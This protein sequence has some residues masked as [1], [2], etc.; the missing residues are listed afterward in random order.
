[1]LDAAAPAPGAD[2]DDALADAFLSWFGGR[3]DLYAR[4]WHDDR[5]RRS[6]Y[7]PVREPLTADVALAH[8]RGSITVGQ[9]LLFPDATVAYAVLDLDLSA[10]ALAEVRATAGDDASPC[11]HPRLRSYAARLIDCAA[12]L[13]IPLWP[14]D[15]GGRGMHLWL[16]FRPRRPARA[17]RALLAQIVTAAGAQPADVSVEIF[18]KQDRPGRRGLSSLVKLPLGIHRGSLR[19]CPLLDDR[20]EPI[21]DP[22]AALARL[23]PA[24]DACVAD[25]LGRRLAP[26]P[27]PEVD[28]PAGPA[29]ALVAVDSPRS[30]AERLRAI[31][32][33][34]DERAACER[35]L[36]GCAV[37][38]ALVR[39]AY[40][41]RRLEPAELSAVIYTLGL[42]GPACQLADDVLA[43]ARAPRAEL[44][45]AR[46]GIPSPAGCRRLRRI[47][48]DAAADCRCFDG[49]D[50][51]PY[52]TPA[53]FATGE[54]A[55]APPSWAPFA[56]WL[57]DDDLVAD[58]IETLGQW[59]R[60]IDERLER[61]E[62]L[63]ADADPSP[64]PPGAGAG[65]DRNSTGGDA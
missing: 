27:A 58:P 5:R 14:A 21:G 44:E 37:L 17:A 25:V 24:D 48:P 40:E 12:R 61:L 6:G 45:R 60:R 32:P 55:P 62:R 23:R 29:P 33:G 56:A 53:L 65:G 16:F 57:D 15:S 22:A 52:A 1:L 20:L 19:P 8:L 13:G 50:P 2:P 35:M 63:Q 31:A 10:D 43:A 18:P 36:S 7:R 30:L 42:V 64:E 39:R 54:T 26:L 47:C 46:R 9:Y 11:R 49:A 34:D 51:V 38:R 28:P 59:V 3:R 41:R 4:Q